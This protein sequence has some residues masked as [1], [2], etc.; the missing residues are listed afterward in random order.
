MRLGKPMR[1]LKLVLLFCLVLL[2]PSVLHSSLESKY[3]ST[4]AVTVVGDWSP[5]GYFIHDGPNFTREIYE[6]VW[7]DKDIKYVLTEEGLNK[8]RLRFH[9]VISYEINRR[10][11]GTKIIHFLLNRYPGIWRKSPLFPQSKRLRCDVGYIYGPRFW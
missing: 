8:D 4:S 6:N 2:F 5:A 9:R 11:D 7:I 1:F 10:P 3:V